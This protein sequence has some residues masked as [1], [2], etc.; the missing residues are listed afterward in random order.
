MEATAPSTN[1]KATDMNATD[2]TKATIPYSPCVVCGVGGDPV[3][4]IH[5]SHMNT[6]DTL[7]EAARKQFAAEHDAAYAVCRAAQ[8]AA[9]KA[10]RKVKV[11]DETKA[12][13][14]AAQATNKAAYIA[15]NRAAQAK[16]A[17][18]VK[19]N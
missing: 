3:G 19:G 15:A 6:T 17:A 8:T 1:R 9:K 13:Y 10:Y 16:Y 18:T 12:A 11:T 7:T 5:L 14:V 4:R 2:A